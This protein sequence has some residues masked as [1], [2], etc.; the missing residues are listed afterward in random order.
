LS[1]TTTSLTETTPV[2]PVEHFEL[3]AVPSGYIAGEVTE[4]QASYFRIVYAKQ[5]ED[6]THSGARISLDVQA[7]GMDPSVPPY[8]EVSNHTVRGGKAARFFIVSDRADDAHARH[9]LTWIE[10]TQSRVTIY[11]FNNDPAFFIGL[12]ESVRRRQ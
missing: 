6:A 4:S 8:T 9:G 5:G 2:Q 3:S 10:T 12:A 7:P 11:A 1:T